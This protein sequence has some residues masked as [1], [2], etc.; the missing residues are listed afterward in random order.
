MDRCWRFEIL[1]LITLGL[2]LNRTQAHTHIK[3]PLIKVVTGFKRS[4]WLTG[5][6]LLPIHAHTT[7]S[8]EVF[9]FVFS[10]SVFIC[11]FLKRICFV[12]AIF[13]VW[14]TWWSSEYLFFFSLFLYTFS[15]IVQ[16]LFPLSLWRYTSKKKKKERQSKLKRLWCSRCFLKPLCFSPPFSVFLPF[17]SLCP[18]LVLFI[19]KTDWRFSWVQQGE[20]GAQEKYKKRSQ[21]TRVAL[22]QERRDRESR[23]F[24]HQILDFTTFYLY[25]DI[26]FFVRFVLFCF[27]E[28]QQ[29]Q[30]QKR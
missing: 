21:I 1:L 15:S 13:V 19:P 3:N 4:K 26:P 28:A 24:C 18:L 17:R 10:S 5:V 7:P 9:V 8:K 25:I 16:L 30:R 22:E 20:R 12:V 14:S 11:I 6:L 29:Q 27:K 23:F 2:F